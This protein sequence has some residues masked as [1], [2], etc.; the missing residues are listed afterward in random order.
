MLL[1]RKGEGPAVTPVLVSEPQALPV[2]TCYS[3][4]HVWPLVFPK[5][6][7]GE[8]ILYFLQWSSISLRVPKGPSRKKPH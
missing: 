1:R 3:T 6:L 7:S 8:K 4:I 5:L 2:F